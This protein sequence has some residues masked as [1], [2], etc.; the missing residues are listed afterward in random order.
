MTDKQLKDMK[1]GETLYVPAWAIQLDANGVP[2]INV[3]YTGTQQ[4]FGTSTTPVDRV[5]G[6]FNSYAPNR[7]PFNVDGTPRKKR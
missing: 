1:I 6:G 7:T 3:Y 5:P 4:Q 2:C